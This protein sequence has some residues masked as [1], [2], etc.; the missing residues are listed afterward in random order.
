L[1]NSVLVFKICVLTEEAGVERELLV[2]GIGGQGVQL[3][4][5]VLARAAMAEGRT[6]QV[7]GSYGG[8]M[9]GGSTEA[10]VVVADG[11][12]ESPPTVSEAWSAILMHHDY[13]E[14]TLRCLRP[15]AVVLVNSS[16]FSLPIERARYTVLD[17][18]ATALAADVGNVMAAS[19]VM[20]GAYAAATGL[21]GLA[22]LRDAARGALPTYRSQHIELNDRALDAGFAAAPALVAP[23]W[24]PDTVVVG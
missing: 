19:M 1:Q 8:M 7:F 9:R 24:V 20:A 2:T 17:V 16:V 5:T 13:S 15:G 3:V 23:A 18:P 10:T 22:A 4:A 11:P 14:H 6:V 21:V 12:I